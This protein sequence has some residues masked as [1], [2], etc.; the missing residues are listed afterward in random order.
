MVSSFGEEEDAG[1][2][3]STAINVQGTEGLETEQIEVNG[4]TVVLPVPE[5]VVQTVNNQTVVTSGKVDSE[6]LVDVVVQNVVTFEFDLEP[7]YYLVKAHSAEDGSTAYFDEM[8][9]EL[10]Q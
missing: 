2:Q 6:T 8:E 5:T 1:T 4:L 9:T 3:I 7:E 10:C